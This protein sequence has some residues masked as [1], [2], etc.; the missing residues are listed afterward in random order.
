MLY[1]NFSNGT[2]L[3]GLLRNEQAAQRVADKPLVTMHIIHNSRG[4]LA[5]CHVTNV[6]Y[7]SWPWLTWNMHLRSQNSPYQNLYYHLFM[8]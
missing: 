1:C 4:K 3:L 7:I 6:L 5:N 8:H 2:S